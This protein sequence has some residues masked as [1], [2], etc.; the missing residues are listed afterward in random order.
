MAGGINF[1]FPTTIQGHF[2]LP[3]QPT[4]HQIPNLK[5]LYNIFGYLIQVKIFSFFE[6][7]G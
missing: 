7:E 3:G 6:M 4:Q 2:E 5:T 1:R